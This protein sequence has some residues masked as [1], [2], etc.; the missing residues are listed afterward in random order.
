MNEASAT[1]PVSGDIAQK[2]IDFFN[3]AIVTN[4]NVVGK[5]E[6][7]G[8]TVIDDQNVLI[9]IN[10]DGSGSAKC[11]V[12]CGNALFSNTLLNALKGAL[13]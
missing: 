13:A 5:Y 2:V 3:V 12:N 6:F 9:S 10:S 8:K 11:R 1:L 4:D 7:A